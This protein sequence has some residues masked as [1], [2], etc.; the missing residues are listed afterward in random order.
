MI[1]FGAP[2]RKL[3]QLAEGLI[4]S[5]QLTASACLEKIMAVKKAIET[6]KDNVARIEGCIFFICINQF[7]INWILSPPPQPV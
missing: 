7:L 6:T 4:L 2:I 5:V 3:S 1:R